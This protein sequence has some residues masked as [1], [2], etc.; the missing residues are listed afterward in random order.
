MS[1]F[2]V[3]V[4]QKDRTRNMNEIATLSKSL[5]SLKASVNSFSSKMS[6]QSLERK[7]NND[8]TL[9]SLRAKFVNTDSQVPTNLSRNIFDPLNES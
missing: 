1:T 5:E 9:R 2:K 7:S 4:S 6:K 8:K 3:D